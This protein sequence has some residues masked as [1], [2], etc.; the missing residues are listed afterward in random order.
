MTKII[1]ARIECK[2][3][4]NRQCQAKEINLTADSIATLYNGRQ[5]FNTCKTFEESEESKEFRKKFFEILFKGNN[6][7]N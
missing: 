2:Y 6:N 5:E 1:C 4:K 7:E 3:C